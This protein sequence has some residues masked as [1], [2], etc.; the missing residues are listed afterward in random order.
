MRNIQGGSLLG[1]YRALDLTDEKG[2]FA[3]KILADMGADV[4]KVERPG[5][6]SARNI[7]PFYKDIPHP[8]KSLFWFAFNTGK[9]S[10]TLDIKSQQGQDIF[11]RLARTA[12]VVIESFPVGYLK[13]IG[14]GYNTLR[15]TSKQLIMASISAFGQTGPYKD[16]QGEDIT[17][18]AMGGL[19]QVCGDE[20]RAPVQVGTPQTYLAASL[21]AVESILTAL[22]ARSTIGGG[23]FI[24]I[25]ARDGV[26][27]SESEMVPYWTLLRENSGR[28]GR[29]REPPGGGIKVPVIWPCKDGFVNYI[30]QGGQPGAERNIAITRWLDEEGYASDYLRNKDWYQFDWRK[31]T[32][33]EM[34]LFLKPLSR[35]FAAHTREELYAEAVKR[36]IGLAPTADVTD[37]IASPQLE[38]RRYW[39]K[40]EHA[41]LDDSLIYPGAFAVMSETPITVQH[42]APL[43]GEHNEEVYQGELGIPREEALVLKQTG[44]I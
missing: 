11:K 15:R 23:Q 38:A 33:E 12:D 13:T 10:I 34:G 1:G 42:R 31:I 30:V 39:T 26:V 14:L 32:Q 28:H 25:S 43:I 9:R 36:G 41:E 4:I 2:L 16:Y 7:G 20:E 35:L 17:V 19:M 29:F 40:L 5:G 6:D 21:D 8:E 27:W 22:Y 18:L 3:G 24:D 44:V 37:L